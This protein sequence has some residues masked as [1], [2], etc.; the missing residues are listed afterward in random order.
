MTDS[1]SNVGESN[2]ISMH[3][4]HIEDENERKKVKGRM[5]LNEKER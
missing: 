5:H 1:L 3:N 2:V 4:Y